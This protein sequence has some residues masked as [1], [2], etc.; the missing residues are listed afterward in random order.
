MHS[1]RE[2][3]SL[4]RTR[5]LGNTNLGTVRAPPPPPTAR[6]RNLQ[7]PAAR[8]CSAAC[9]PS[10]ANPCLLE[11]A[12]HQHPSSTPIIQST[13]HNTHRCSASCCPSRTQPACAARSRPWRCAA[14]RRRRLAATRARQRGRGGWWEACIPPGSPCPRRTHTHA[15][16]ALPSPA[17]PRTCNQGGQHGS[18]PGVRR[19]LEQAQSL[20]GARI[21][22]HP[23]RHHGGHR[24][25]VPLLDRQLRAWCA[26]GAGE[27]RC[28]ASGQAVFAGRECVRGRLA[29]S[30]R[31]PAGQAKGSSSS[32]P[33][34]SA[35]PARA[36]RPAPCAGQGWHP[37]PAARRRP[38]GAPPL[39]PSSAG[40][41]ASA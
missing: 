33:T 20:G 1:R 14:P 3:H 16:P 5:M 24:R 35:P 32:R 39:R 37:L 15:H 28:R 9:C 38:R 2:G 27:A 29:R 31:R 6:Q 41:G 21:G 17:L 26:S 13:P 7:L 34:A 8:R 4:L 19:R 40:S 36:W 22:V 10:T 12:T 25:R 23:T 30:G 11:G 18:M